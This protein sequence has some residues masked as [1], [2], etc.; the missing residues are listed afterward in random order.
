MRG[1]SQWPS[2]S[3]TIDLE[4][5]LPNAGASPLSGPG[6]FGRLSASTGGGSRAAPAER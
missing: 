6:N 4:I 2:A 1:N 5:R 3:G